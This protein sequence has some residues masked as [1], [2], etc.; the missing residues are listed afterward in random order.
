MLQGSNHFSYS[1]DPSRPNGQRVNRASVAIN[2]R[3]IAPAG[4]YRVV[5]PDFL[6]SGGG[7]LSVATEGT[8]PVAA[9]SDVD[10]FVAYLGKHSPL[11]PG[12][13]NRVQRTR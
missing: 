10:V 3:T 8:D 5:M 4:R 9:D 7:G 11:G 13:Q 1:F 12:P 2:G 6:W